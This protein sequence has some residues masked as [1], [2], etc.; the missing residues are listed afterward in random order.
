MKLYKPAF[1]FVLLLLQQTLFAQTDQSWTLENC[2]E[3]AFKNNIQIR[4]AGVTAEISKNENLQSKLNLL[5]SI[6]GNLN[7]SNNFGNGFNPQTYSFAEGNSQ[8]VQMSL[9]GTLPV[10]TGLQQMFNIQRTKF[11]L[12][13]SNYDYQ[14]ARRNIAL[15]I[16]SAYLQILL[17]REILSVA[18]K[19]KQLTESQRA[20]LQSRISAGSLPETSG[21][22]VESQLA[23]DEANIVAAQNAVDLATLALKQLLQLGDQPFEIVVP[24]IQLENVAD[25][26]AL[27]SQNIYQT[28][29]ATQPSIMSAQARVQSANAS[30]KM[31]LGALSPTIA[32]FG[33]LSAGY[34]SQDALYRSR[35]D[36]LNI[37]GVSIPFPQNEFDRYKTFREGL[38]DNFRKVV[39]VSLNVPLFSRWQRVTN[40]QNA[41]LQMQIRELQL[42]GT[43]NQLRT[44]IE[45]AYTNTK[46]AIQSYYAN[47]K[48]LETADKSY[49]ALEKRY[50]A[51]MLGTFELQQS[52]TNL[53]YAQS[54]MIKAKY[55]YVFRL[56][57]LDFYQGKPIT[58]NQ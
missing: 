11:E 12:L 37:G 10:F 4:Q 14:N 52:K 15:N 5:P 22:E 16:A 21:Y 3:Y 28:A 45:Q 27:S 26:T 38:R 50:N 8:S 48:S 31:A 53:A 34:F 9:Q 51:G 56:K 2:I 32:V 35:V 57:V 23:R 7:F 1:V 54:E 24:D 25:V 6:E 18:I 58:L 41:R 30:R 17:N 47:K 55:T 36:T 40:V 33:N 20:S 19:Q 44:D 42:E 39:G 49:L 46:A 29:L 43:K 13:A